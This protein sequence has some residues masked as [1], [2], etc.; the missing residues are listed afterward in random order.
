MGVTEGKLALIFISSPTIRLD[1]GFDRS[2][3][4]RGQRLLSILRLTLLASIR[5]ARRRSRRLHS[6]DRKIGASTAKP[7]R[8]R[9][10]LLLGLGHAASGPH[11]VLYSKLAI[12]VF[13]HVSAVPRDRFL[14]LADIGIH[15]LAVRQASA[16]HSDERAK[17][18]TKEEKA[19]TLSDGH[20]GISSHR[21]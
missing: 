21:R 10:Q 20:G 6:H 5:R 9:L 18:A 14:R 8:H 13:G 3:H 7:G 2:H 15:P 19:E 4:Q 17:S 11:G 12:S 16:R 1:R